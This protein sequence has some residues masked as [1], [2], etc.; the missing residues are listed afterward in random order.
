MGVNQT[1]QKDHSL[2]KVYVC[3]PI[4]GTNGENDPVVVDNH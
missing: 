3:R 1:G 2:A 4:I